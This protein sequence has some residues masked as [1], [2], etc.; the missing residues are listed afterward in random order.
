MLIDRMR[1]P[2]W[3]SSRGA[4]VALAAGVGIAAAATAGTVALAATSPSPSPSPSQGSKSA[5]PTPD[6]GD[7]RGFLA[8]GFGR[9]GFG[10][11][12]LGGPGFALHGEFVVP[13]NGGGYETIDTQQGS[14]TAVS[15][16]SITL[17]SEDGFTKTYKVTS[18]TLVNAARDGIGTVKTG[19][20]VALTAT[21]SD[22]TA[23]A[24]QV[25]DVSLGRSLF[26]RWA[27][28]RPDRA[29][30]GGQT[31]GGGSSSPSS[32]SASPSGTGA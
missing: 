20:T 28:E 5:P 26:K 16:D 24:V 14:V 1:T 21:V 19:D 8:R 11:P 15:K 23:T 2:R 25:T 29:G 30:P 10:G 27:P 3:V 32:Q 22:G 9:H 7:H 6:K 4:R 12:G 13:K 17:K 18:D 31:P